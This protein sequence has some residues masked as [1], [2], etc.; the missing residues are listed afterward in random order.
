MTTGV[1]LLAA[2]RGRRFGSDKR[3]AVLADGRTLLGSCTDTLQRATLPF[4]VCLG[5]NDKALA[6]ELAGRGVPWMQCANSERGMGHTLSDAMSGIPANWSGV[7][8]ALADMPWIR[9]ETYRA[10]AERLSEETIVVPVY[11]GV[12]GNPVGF[13]R[14]FF[15]LLRQLGGDRGARGLVTRFPASVVEL[16]CEDEGIRQDVDTPETLSPGSESY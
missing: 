10:L 6:E 1:L 4:I 7:L 13:G 15:P 5:V 9:P 11:H 2:G 8:I 14:N 12:P 3:R 16:P